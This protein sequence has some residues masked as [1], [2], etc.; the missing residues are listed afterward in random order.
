[1]NL[2]KL[3]ISKAPSIEKVTEQFKS[4][5]RKQMYKMHKKS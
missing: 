3:K 4:A 1:M 2:E 5:W